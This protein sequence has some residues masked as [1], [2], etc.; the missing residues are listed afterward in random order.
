MGTVAT[1]APL[2]KTLMLALAIMALVLWLADQVRMLWLHRLH[3]RFACDLRE[4]TPRVERLERSIERL[5]YEV[6]KMTDELA[7]VDEVYSGRRR[8]RDA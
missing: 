8:A 4:D 6:G 5:S 2:I 1:W 3:I 7:T